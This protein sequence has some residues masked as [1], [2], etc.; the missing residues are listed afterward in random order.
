MTVFYNRTVRIFAGIASQFLFVAF[1]YAQRTPAVTLASVVGAAKQHLPVML[2]KQALVNSA[3]AGITDARH[4]RIPELKVLEEVSGASSNSIAGAYFPLGTVPSVSGSIRNGNNF[5]PALGNIGML[6]TE[7]DLVDFGLKKAAVQNAEAYAKLAGTDFQRQQYLLGWQAGK[8]YFALLQAT[9][10]LAIEEQ[11]VNRYNDIYKIIQAVTLSGIRPGSDSSQIIA[12]VSSTKINYNLTLDK[13]QQLKQQL[14]YLTGMPPDNINIDTSAQSLNI[15]V[16][17]QLSGAA[18]TSGNPFLAFYTAQSNYFKANQQ[19]INKSYQPKIQLLGGFWG[20][21]S[22]IQYNDQYKGINSGIGYQ[23]FN[24]AAAVAFTYN[25]FDAVHRRDKLAEN[26]YKISA[27]NYALQQEQQD[28]GNELQ[29][30]NIT[31]GTTQQ[32]LKEMPIQL[33]AAKD[34]YNQ[35]LAQYDA[36]IINLLDL[37]NASYTL[38]RAQTDYVEAVNNWYL[39]NLDKAAITGNLDQFIQT[40]KK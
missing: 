5:Q 7:Y 12:E 35:K 29:Q 25:L 27:G 32:N 16:L 31:I 11:N 17:P 18:D 30:T 23:R 26:R 39:S 19:L 3:G 8:T 22:G 13:V 28:L 36:G 6:Y 24:Y 37:I 10:Q 21:G 1:L 34:V 20:R 38:Y 40:I 33:Q 4:S 9:Y 14:S 2:E 15:P